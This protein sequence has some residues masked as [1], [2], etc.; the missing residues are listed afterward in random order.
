MSEGNGKQRKTLTTR[1]GHPVY[2]NQNQRTI[3]DRGPAR[4]RTITSSRR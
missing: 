4:S 1:Q 2:D 3:G